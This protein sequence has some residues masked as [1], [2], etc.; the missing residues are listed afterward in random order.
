MDG[1]WGGVRLESKLKWL[2]HSQEKEEQIC[3][4]TSDCLNS[5][6]CTADSI[7]QTREM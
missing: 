4:E 2:D 1:G 3:E 6:R 7:S 5:D